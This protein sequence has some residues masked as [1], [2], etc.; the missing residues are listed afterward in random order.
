MNDDSWFFVSINMTK[1]TSLSSESFFN[2]YKKYLPP[3]MKTLKL[4]RK[5][6]LKNKYRFDYIVTTFIEYSDCIW[7]RITPRI[8]YRILKKVV[9]DMHRINFCFSFNPSVAL[10]YKTNKQSDVQ[11]Y[12]IFDDPVL[13]E[14]LSNIDTYEKYEELLK[15]V[16]KFYKEMLNNKNS[17]SLINTLFRTIHTFKVI[18][19]FEHKTFL[20]KVL[21]SDDELLKQFRWPVKTHSDSETYICLSDWIYN[22]RSQVYQLQ[23]SMTCNCKNNLEPYYNKYRDYRNPNITTTASY[24]IESMFVFYSHLI[25]NYI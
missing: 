1:K 17:Q 4:Y 8:T 20:C 2:Q 3:V 14:C 5:F 7:P 19:A 13:G 21:D 9:T 12:P 11:L 24:L 16:V 22:E 15:R 10:Y 23:P 18:L 25:T 6:I